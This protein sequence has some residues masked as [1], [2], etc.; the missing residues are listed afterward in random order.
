MQRHGFTSIKRRFTSVERG[1]TTTK[2]RFTS[3]E[4]GFPSVERRN[5]KYAIPA[6]IYIGNPLTDFRRKRGQL[7]DLN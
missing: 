1:F 7:P 5:L 2:R 6:P 3:V 4:R